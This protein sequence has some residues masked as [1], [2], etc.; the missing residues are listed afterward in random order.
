MAQNEMRAKPALPERVRSMEGLGLW[1]LLRLK[2]VD[3][4]IKTATVSCKGNF[5]PGFPS[6]GCAEDRGRVVAQ[7]SDAANAATGLPKWDAKV[8]YYSL[9]ISRLAYRAVGRNS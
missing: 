6:C 7:A 4:P 1:C 2:V 3:L 8:F 9:Y 5:G